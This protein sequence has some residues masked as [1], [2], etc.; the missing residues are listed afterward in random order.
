MDIYLNS[1]RK[2]F[3]S[4]RS[5]ASSLSLQNFLLSSVVRHFHSSTHCLPYV[6]LALCAQVH[7]LGVV[8]ITS[9]NIL[10]SNPA[11]LEAKSLL[12]N[13]LS[14]SHNTHCLC[15]VHSFQP[16]FGSCREGYQIPPVLWD[17]RLTSVTC[18]SECRSLYECY[19]EKWVW[20]RP[21]SACKAIIYLLLKF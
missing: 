14:F 8:E 2:Y 16:P 11:V 18:A 13:L 4:I 19:E 3:L 7:I 17:A 15:T 1:W 10:Y 6:T 21:N 12:F 20:V 5:T 9:V